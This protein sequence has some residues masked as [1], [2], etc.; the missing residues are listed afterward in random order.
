MKHKPYTCY[1]LQIALSL[2]M[3]LKKHVLN[4]RLLFKPIQD[5]SHYTKYSCVYL[6]NVY[7]ILQI[8]LSLC[9][10]LKKHVLNV[11]L[12]FKPTDKSTSKFISLYSGLK[13]SIF[14]P[15]TTVLFCIIIFNTAGIDLM[16]QSDEMSKPYF[17]AA[18]SKEV[19]FRSGPN[20]RYPIVFT[21]Y[22]KFEPLKVINKFEHWRQVEDSVGDRGWVHVSNLTAKKIVKTKSQ[23]HL[24]LYNKPDS[25]TAKIVA[26]IAND[27][28]LHVISCD[29][30]WCKVEHTKGKGWIE[31]QYLWGAMQ[32]D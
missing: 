17:V 1:I 12:L 31:A 13:C 16:A 22:R 15:V 30:K 29:S 7:D 21:L 20:A 9:M 24:N 28:L 6:T 26:Y 32:N 18:K 19:N 3:S 5:S 8:A 10:S 4:V 11:R 27:V 2:C 14:S 23:Q 25:E